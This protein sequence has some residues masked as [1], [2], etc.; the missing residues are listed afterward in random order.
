MKRIPEVGVGILMLIMITNASATTATNLVLDYTT[1]GVDADLKPG[2]SGILT[3]VVVNSGGYAA[4]NVQVWIPDTQDVHAA[5]RWY[6]GNIEP[7]SSKTVTTAANVDDDA[8]VGLHTLQARLT[9]NGRNSDGDAESN[10]MV[11]WDIPL[12]VYGKAS[13][14]FS[15][16]EASYAEDMENTLTVNVK[17]KVNAREVASKL[18]SNCA[19]IVGSD[20]QY[21]GDMAAQ[22]ENPVTYYIKPTQVGICTLTLSLDY[23]DASGNEATEN[24]SIGINVERSSIDLKIVDIYDGDLAIGG[25]SGVTLEI[26][27][28][29]NNP[30][31]DVTVTLNLSSPFTPVKSSQKYIGSIKSDETKNG[32]FA[33]SVD[34]SAKKKSYSIPVTLEYYDQAGNKQ[35]TSVNIGL[36]VGGNAD[37]RVSLDEKETLMAGSAGKVTIG[38]VNRGFVDA[39]FLTIKLLS[40]GS[41]KVTSADSSYIGALNSDDSDSQDFEISIYGNVTE[42]LIPLV[43]RVEYKEENNDKLIL[44][45]QNIDINLLSQAEYKKQTSNGGILPLLIGLLGLVLAIIV[46]YLGVWFIARLLGVVTNLLDKKIFKRGQEEED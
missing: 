46:L 13:F 35:T 33:I 15:V 7:G 30:A 34:S 3:V 4:E 1:T 2:D 31:S 16:K 42:E 19:S 44:E 21:L 37:I 41:Y 20:K 36:S 11:S 6:I 40:T 38:V 24:T 23:S 25:V 29:G 43:V 5:K 18:S 39:K 17:S 10:Q 12:R 14:Q 26:K 28:L 32:S 9:Y 45:E 27:N 22:G 8:R